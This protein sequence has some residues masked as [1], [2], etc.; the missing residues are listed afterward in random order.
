MYMPN[1]SEMASVTLRRLS[2]LFKLPMSKTLDHVKEMMLSQVDPRAVCLA[3]KD[4]S[5]CS[6]CFF[7]KLTISPATLALFASS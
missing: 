5:R 7:N 1:E 2:W 4:K 6:K 3:C